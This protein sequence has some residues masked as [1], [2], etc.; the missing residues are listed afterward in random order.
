MG[1]HGCL[2]C[3]RAKAFL[4]Q[5]CHGVLLAWQVSLAV[6]DAQDHVAEGRESDP[7]ARGL[8]PLAAAKVDEVES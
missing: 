1:Q 7:A 5:E 4:Q 3:Q 6:E 2:T 8:G